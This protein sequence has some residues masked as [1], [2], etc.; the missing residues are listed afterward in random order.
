MHFYLEKSTKIALGKISYVNICKLAQIT[1][2]VD[3]FR[4]GVPPYYIQLK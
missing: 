1:Q 3:S 4:Q 2:K